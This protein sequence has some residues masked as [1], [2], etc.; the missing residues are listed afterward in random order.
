MKKFDDTSLKEFLER[1]LMCKSIGN[2]EKIFIF[3]QEVPKDLQNQMNE[4]LESFQEVR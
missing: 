4:I 2:L 3:F 1:G